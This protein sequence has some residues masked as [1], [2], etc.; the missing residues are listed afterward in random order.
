M[1]AAAAALFWGLSAG[2]EPPN[3]L[4]AEGAGGRG[5]VLGELA[6][7]PDSDPLNLRLLLLL[8]TE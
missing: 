7:L 1:V 6:A 5:V 2:G 8:L 3:C 4:R